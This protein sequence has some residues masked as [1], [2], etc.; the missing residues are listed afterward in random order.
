MTVQRDWYPGDKYT[1]GPY[2]AISSLKGARYSIITPDVEPFVAAVVAE[3]P[4][5]E[6]A[7]K[8]IHALNGRPVPSATGGKS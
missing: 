8:I 3:V 4:D 2:D 5:L 6:T 7:R 1:L